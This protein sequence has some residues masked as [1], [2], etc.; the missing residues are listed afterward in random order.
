MSEAI[1]GAFG[2]AEPVVRHF[3][4]EIMRGRTG[5]DGWAD[6]LKEIEA[7][8]DLAPLNVSER[9][10]VR[11][12]SAA[13]GT[14]TPCQ[15]SNKCQRRPAGIARRIQVRERHVEIPI[16]VHLLGA[17]VVL[18]GVVEDQSGLVPVAESRRNRQ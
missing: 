18:F 1:V 15:G 14:R 9:S 4:A 7:I 17:V 11:A 6:A 12:A 8:L 13:I 10:A 2:A 16:L 3:R 5:P